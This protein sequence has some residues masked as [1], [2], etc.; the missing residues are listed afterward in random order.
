MEHEVQIERD[1]EGQDQKEHVVGIE[2]EGIGVA[3]KGLP[4]GPGRVERRD[5]AFFEL[6]RSKSLEGEMDSEDIAQRK[7]ALT[8]GN[9]QRDP[10]P[11]EKQNRPE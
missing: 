7:S 6:L 1:P 11:N 10:K 2:R 9:R 5:A 4:Q 8:Q 3:A